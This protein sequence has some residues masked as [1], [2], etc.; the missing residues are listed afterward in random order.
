VSTPTQLSA[1]DFE[2]ASKPQKRVLWKWSLVVT[3]FLLL[4]LL[5]QCGSASY[6]GYKSGDKVVQRFHTQLN[7]GDY[8]EICS[9]ADEAF[10]QSGTHDEALH[11]L[12]Q[13]HK[14]LGNAGSAKQVQVNVSVT[15]QGAFVTSLF[16]TQFDE[17]T[18]QET[19]I[20]RKNGLDLKLYRYNVQSPV[21]LK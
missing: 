14:K 18:A 7:A 1:P 15:T 10:S 8:E 16:S 21:F 19:F 4:F 9:E 13:V 5:W 2:S 3:A 11:F 17:G 20:W 6:L 12:D